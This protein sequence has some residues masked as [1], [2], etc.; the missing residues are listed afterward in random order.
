MAEYRE[1]RTALPWR[2]VVSGGAVPAGLMLVGV[3]LGAAVDPAWFIAVAVVPICPPFSPYISLLWRNRRTGIVVDD[4]GV[5][6]GAPDGG[7]RLVSGLMVRR[8]VGADRD[9]RG[10][11][12]RHDERPPDLQRKS[13]LARRARPLALHARRRRPSAALRPDRADRRTRCADRNPGSATAARRYFGNYLNVGSFSRRYE[14]QESSLW[15]V[16]SPRPEDLASSLAEHG[17]G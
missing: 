10:G 14:P 5:R 7:P 6:I 1:T 16:P 8:S 4:A 17:L 2:L 13:V 3:V 15:L 11:H 12:R 9:Q